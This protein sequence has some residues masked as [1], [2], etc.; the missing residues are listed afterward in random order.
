MSK[1]MPKPADRTWLKLAACRADDVD[2]E[3]FFPDQNVAGL[4]KAR[5]I[6]K[7]CPVARQCLADCLEAEGGRAAANRHGVYA[8]MTPKQRERLYRRVQSNTQAAA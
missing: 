8:G 6:C 1:R 5:A 3:T 7:G 4:A 2:P